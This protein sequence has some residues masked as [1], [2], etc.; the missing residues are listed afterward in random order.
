[1]P[2]VLAAGHRG[3]EA[4]FD[5][6]RVELTKAGV[7]LVV[8]PFSTREELLAAA[9]GVDALIESSLPYDRELLAE[10]P[11]LKALCAR[12][13]G[14][15]RFDLDA[16]T[17][18]GIVCINLPRVFHREVA[19][20]ALSLWLALVRK[21]VPLN[22]WMKQR[23]SADKMSLPRPANSTPAHHIYGETFGIVSLGNIGRVVAGLLRP[24]EMNL[25]AFD[26]FVKPADAEA[27][28]VKLVGSLDELFE[29]ADFVSAHTPL[30]KATHHMIGY[31]QF[32]RMKPTS[33]FINTGRGPVVD[34][35]GLIR[36]LREGKLAGAGL[37]VQEKEPPDPDNPL[38]TMDNV[39]LTPHVA[40][41]S[42]KARV[43]RARWIGIELGRVLNG[44]W[45]QHGLV[46][47]S[48][49]PRFP[50][51]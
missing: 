1:M 49:K 18:L 44:Q 29:Q 23:T 16:A 28:G 20:H 8:K 2:K 42:D 38:L 27:L 6:A 46:N 47:K 34:E 5:P 51:G 12:G 11:E 31:Q 45:P 40:S 17:E 39:I 48:V 37:D 26:P 30:S 22:D 50:I 13:I 10:L 35:A 7:E 36:A 3:D 15:D 41:A 24:F 32:S 25:I 43:E 4:F 9:Q 14:V 21:V 33:L 19:H